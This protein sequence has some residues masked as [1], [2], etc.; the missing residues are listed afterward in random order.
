[1]FLLLAF[2]VSK[3]SSCWRVSPRG[4]WGAIVLR[5]QHVIRSY[6]RPLHCSDPREPHEV[7]LEDPHLLGHI[8]SLEFFHRWPRA[9]QPLA[10]PCSRPFTSPHTHKQSR[11]SVQVISKSLQTWIDLIRGHRG[12]NLGRIGDKM[13]VHVNHL[14]SCMFQ[15]LGPD[16]RPPSTR[17]K[18]RELKYNVLAHPKTSVLSGNFR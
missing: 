5:G 15:E 17:K 18:I 7:L 11:W 2:W 12:N 3:R 10:T 13:T 1:M 6:N 14:C 16:K 8:L 9:V 4:L